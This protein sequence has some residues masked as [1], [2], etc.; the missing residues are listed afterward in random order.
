MARACN[1]LVKTFLSVG[2]IVLIVGCSEKRDDELLGKWRNN[3]SWWSLEFKPN[4]DFELQNDSGV[5]MAV[6]RTDNDGNLY[7]EQS[8][9]G[10]S[11]RCKYSTAVEG[12]RKL[13]NLRGCSPIAGMTD[14]T[15]FRDLNE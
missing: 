14:F 13:V 2:F 4:G 12:N 15:M 9:P 8:S 11:S 7:L 3:F 1:N 6:W 5:F 10:L